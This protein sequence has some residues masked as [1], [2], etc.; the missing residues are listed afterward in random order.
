[1]VTAVGAA[2]VYDTV[3]CVPLLTT[4][5]FNV[6]A[7]GTVN[8]LAVLTEQSVTYVVGKTLEFP[9]HTIRTAPLPPAPAFTVAEPAEPTTT[10]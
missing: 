10:V 8:K 1:M 4:T 6:G 3:A 7:G 5:E 9:G 2:A